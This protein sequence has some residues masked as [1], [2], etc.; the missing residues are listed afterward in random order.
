MEQIESNTQ[1]SLS[2]QSTTTLS[3]SNRQRDAV[4]FLKLYAP[5]KQNFY[6][7]QGKERIFV[8]TAPK[9]SEVS[10]QYGYKTAIAWLKTQI[11]DLNNQLGYKYKMDIQQI[12]DCSSLIL[13]RHSGLKVTELMYFFRSMK[14][15]DYGEY[16]GTCN[17]TN[18]L[19]GLNKFYDIRNNQLKNIYDKEK[20]DARNERERKRK[21]SGLLAAAEYLN[22]LYD[23][24]ESE[25]GAQRILE[26]FAKNDIKV[27][28]KDFPNGR[29]PT[30]A[31]C[32]PTHLIKLAEEREQLMKGNEVQGTKKR[33]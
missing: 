17:M 29:M 28:D 6:C 3:L 22:F 8:G 26:Y 7:T 14:A 19:Q 9:L 30:L 15:G 4:E 5:I 12:D 13:E 23:C 31:E 16:Y 1:I 10:E 33:L 2:N 24:K 27:F 21:A 32:E 18:I 20:E 25:D 11:G